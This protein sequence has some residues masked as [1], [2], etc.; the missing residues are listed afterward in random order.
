MGGN[1]KCRE[2]LDDFIDR[3]DDFSSGKRAVGGRGDNIKCTFQKFFGMK[4]IQ[5]ARSEHTCY[6]VAGERNSHF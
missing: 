2:V 1:L 4:S 3:I 5:F 6:A